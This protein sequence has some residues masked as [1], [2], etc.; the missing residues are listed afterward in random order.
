MRLTIVAFITV[1]AVQAAE[2]PDAAELLE[3]STHALDGYGS[4]QFREALTQTFPPGPFSEPAITLADVT[5]KPPN[6]FRVEPADVS[7]GP[8]WQL[9][10][11]VSNGEVIWIYDP[12]G[13][14]SQNRGAASTVLAPSIAGIWP[15]TTWPETVQPGTIFP[16]IFPGDSQSVPRVVREETI[17]ADGED[18]DCWVVDVT[19]S[20]IEFLLANNFVHLEDVE[21]TIWI[22]R[23]L[24]I[25]WR[26]V[27][28]VNEG[29]VQKERITVAKSNLKLNPEVSDSFFNFVP[30]PEA[31][32]VD[33]ICARNAGNCVH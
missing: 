4:Y 33:R 23:K 18:R 9:R 2:L 27:I 1:C 7:S 20:R 21:M 13:S 32:R 25:D 17:Q 10:T 11:T 26:T 22:D 31:K 28:S 29:S 30:P 3:R 24:L 8:A 6:K 15:G 19:A 5:I 12:D 16:R 14:Y